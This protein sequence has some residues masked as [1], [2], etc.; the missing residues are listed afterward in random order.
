[1]TRELKLIVTFS[2]VEGDDLP[3]ISD[4]ADE[5]TDAGRG[6]IEA[7]VARMGSRGGSLKVEINEV[8]A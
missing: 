2:S 4:K 8:Q 5:L 7:M 6:L 3:G 1:M